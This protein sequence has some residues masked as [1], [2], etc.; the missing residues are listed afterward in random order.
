M[1]YFKITDLTDNEIWYVSSSLPN[2]DNGHKYLVE[3]VSA[4]EYFLEG[5]GLS[6][7]RRDT[8]V[9]DDWDDYDDEYYD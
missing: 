3:E 7:G 9:D 6:L 1:K 2:L 5:E 8:D 4:M